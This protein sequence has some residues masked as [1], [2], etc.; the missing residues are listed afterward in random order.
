VAGMD[1]IGGTAGED[2]TVEAA[3]LRQV[4]ALHPAQVTLEEL[5]REVAIVPE[6]F[7][8]RDA[9]VRAARDLTRAGLLH[10][11][12]ELV[13]PSRAALRFAELLGAP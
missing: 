10:R 6:A 9:I 2:A 13:I 1:D 5:V 11:S 7:E 4:L 8:D 12:G 3:V